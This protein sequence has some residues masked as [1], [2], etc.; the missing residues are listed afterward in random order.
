M[1]RSSKAGE[2]SIG[3]CPVCGSLAPS[4]SRCVC[5]DRDSPE[6]VGTVLQNRYSVQRLLGK[7]NWSRVYLG[8]DTVLNRY[9]AIKA[10]R[11]ELRQEPISLARFTREAQALAILNHANIVTLFDFGVAEN[12]MPF[13]VLE[14]LSGT[15]LAEVIKSRQKIEWRA[16]I[17]IFIQ[18]ASALSFGHDKGVVH[19][20]INP[21]N[22]VIT[23]S[24]AGQ[25]AKLL[26]YGFCKLI[27][28]QFDP[29][30]TEKGVALATSTYMS[31]EMAACKPVDA[32][33]DIYS[34]GCVMYQVLS[35]DVPFKGESYLDIVKQHLSSPPPAFPAAAGVPSWL[36]RIVFRCLQKNPQE[37]FQSCEDLILALKTGSD[38]Q[39]I[40]SDP[41]DNQ[42]KMLSIVLGVVSAILALALIFMLVAR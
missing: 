5:S 3:P 21:A 23:S 10:L 28:E 1:M 14:E 31:P 2:N 16:A 29:K 20:D 41:A 12:S 4:D 26:D 38:Q 27:Y 25:Q 17:D 42:Y 9:V 35:G 19:R 13:L 32:R 22:I 30:L 18:C 37:R 11:T 15:T 24:T 33:S 8:L 39:S 34:M 36:S 7:G 6:L 40:S